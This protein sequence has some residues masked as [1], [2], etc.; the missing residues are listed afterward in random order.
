MADRYDYNCVRRFSG[1]SGELCEGLVE[2][3][4][5]NDVPNRKHEVETKV[6]GIREL[7]ILLG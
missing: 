3:E 7:Q 5:W 6:M 4:V 1:Q 2:D